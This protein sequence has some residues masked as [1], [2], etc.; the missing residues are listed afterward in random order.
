M[1]MK[2]K[3]MADQ[4]VKIKNKA[5]L[6][7]C[8]LGSFLIAVSLILNCRSIWGSITINNLGMF[9]FGSLVIGIL[10]S[11]MSVININI[12]KYALNVLL[13]L[14]IYIFIYLIQPINNSR[15]S[16][17]FFIGFSFLSIYLYTIIFFNTFVIDILIKYYINLLVLICIVSLFFWIFG[18]IFKIIRPTGFVLS[19]WGAQYGRPNIV[20]S[21]YNIY[22][23]TQTLN[24]VI[25]NS[26]IFTE[27]PMASLNFIIAFLFQSLV[28]KNDKYHLLKEIILVLGILSTMSSTGYIA[29]LIIFVMKSFFLDYKN[30]GFFLPFIL[31][32][33]IVS[34]LIIH[35]LLISKL[36]NASGQTRVD[37]FRAGYEAWK[38]HPYMG[39]GLNNNLYQNFMANWR[40]NNLGFS[41]TIMDVLVSGGIYIFILYLI[42]II[43]SVIVSLKTH[44]LNNIIFIVVVAYLFITTIFTNTYILFFLFIFIVINSLKN[45]LVQ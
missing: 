13:F 42:S 32:L 26:A 33:S 2:D 1:K 28:N 25:R 45:K 21:Y 6:A 24:N 19:N 41:N 22:F 29:L 44:N 40:G 30:K 37:D 7:V 38:L 11:F 8:K 3:I 16:D 18:S 36:E 15:L 17:A 43:Y 4:N 39:S 10:F 9:T 12:P 27:A 31:I 23:E 34:V 35:Y 14:S 20:N 5:F